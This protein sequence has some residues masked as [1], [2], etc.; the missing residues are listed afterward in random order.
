MKNH[1]FST[2]LLIIKIC[3]VAFPIGV[4]AETLP[5]KSGQVWT[6]TYSCGQGETN[7]QLSIDNVSTESTTSSNGI[8]VYP[9]T[10]TYIFKSRAGTGSFVIQGAFAPKG[11]IL[12]FTP[13]KWLERPRG[14]R[15]VGMQGN[16]SVDGIQYAG[17]INSN[18]CGNFQVSLDGQSS[19]KPDIARNAL[20]K[21][22]RTIQARIVMIRI[23]CCERVVGQFKRETMLKQR[24]FLT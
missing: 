8:E 2:L 18:G 23:V 14:Y 12:S 13:L 19:S 6:G 17:K 20:P 21:T 10:A 22:N 24:L 16:L 7:L 11:K 4:N 9:I 5:I 15:M 3:I 1:S